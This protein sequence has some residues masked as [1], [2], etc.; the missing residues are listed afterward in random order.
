VCGFSFGFG[1]ALAVLVYELGLMLLPLEPLHQ[2]F[3][4]FG[5]F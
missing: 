5:I 2:T 3:F 1:F 4:V